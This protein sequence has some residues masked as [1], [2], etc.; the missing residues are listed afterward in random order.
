M[1]VPDSQ[2]GYWQ[3]AGEKIKEKMDIVVRTGMDPDIFQ[4]QASLMTICNAQL[5]LA[6]DP[7]K[8]VPGSHARLHNKIPSRSFAS[9]WNNLRM[10]PLA[11]NSE[12]APRYQILRNNNNIQKSEMIGYI[13][14]LTVPIIVPVQ[15]DDW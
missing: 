7:I 1:A 15:F 11:A 6:K 14:W 12:G 9:A 3:G 5:L 10:V 4:K 13:A 2:A 8:I